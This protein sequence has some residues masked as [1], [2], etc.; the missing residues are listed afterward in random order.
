MEKAIQEELKALWRQQ[1]L[2]PGYIAEIEANLRDRIEAYLDEGYSEEKAFSKAIEKA[3]GNPEHIADQYFTAKAGSKRPPWKSNGLYSILPMNFKLVWRGLNKRRGY[4]IINLSGL[5]VGISIS[6]LLWLYVSDQFSYDQHLSESHRVYRINYDLTFDSQQSI[7]SNVAQPVGPALKKEFPEIEEVV[8][9]YKRGADHSAVFSHGEIAFKSDKV[10]YAEEAFLKVFKI[11]ML[12]GDAE[13]ALKE[14]NSIVISEKLAKQLFSTSDVMGETVQLGNDPSSIRKITGIIKD[15]LKTHLP[16]EALLSASI[17][18]RTDEHRW[19]GAHVYTY[20]LLDQH[21]DIEGLKK[22]IP[23]FCER[24]IDDFFERKGAKADLLFQP[25]EEIYLD[26]E[27]IWEL[28]P[29]GNRTNLWVMVAMMFFLIVIAAINYVNLSTAR[30]TE[31]AREVGIR[32]T[33]GSLKRV[34]IGQFMTESMVIT[35]LSG[36][37]SIFLSVAL[38]PFF[39]TLSGLETTILTILTP[40]HLIGILLLSLIIGL[41]AG[42]YPAFYLVSFQPISMLTGRSAK[43]RS[44]DRFRTGLVLVQYSLSS[45]LIIG[46]LF[47]GKQTRFIMNKELG[48]N[49][50]QLVSLKVPDELAMSNSV[51]AFMQEVSS[52]SSIL[53]ATSSYNTLSEDAN[54][55]D[56]IFETPDGQI[57]NTSM[58]RIDIDFNFLQTIQADIIKGR[59]FEETRGDSERRSIVLNEAAVKQYGWE[60]IAT[61]LKLR[62]KN[63]DEEGN[64]LYQSVIGVVSDFSIGPSYQKVAPL[65]IKL[66]EWGARNIYIRVQEESTLNA[67]AHIEESWKETFPGY[68]FDF[69]F[70]DQELNNIYERESMFLKLLK[71][72]TFLI[73]FITSLGIIG[74]ISFTI[75]MKQKE[76]AIR[77]INGAS[78]PAIVRLL[79]Q[80]FVRLLFFAN[81]IAAPIAFYFTRK[82]LFNYDQHVSITAWPFLWSVVI[83]LSFTCMALIYHSLQAAGTNPARAL[84]NE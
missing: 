73:I 5:A 65:M 79:S 18:T 69:A 26:E 50:S 15:H 82:W 8:R 64:P 33:L 39:D 4:T 47:V 12:A 9:F 49:K 42:I 14:P 48:Y 13:D 1:G 71:A 19:L 27:H 45:L 59:D 32:K 17:P 58:N 56:P 20:M 51:S 7:Y 75:E 6:F 62:S 81:L 36:V 29:H 43:G 22:K 78:M 16:V 80:K 67:I 55:N 84:R 38:L 31:R 30:A 25:L 40:L 63:T 54:A 3:I 57:V 21:N 72:M 53:S 44:G 37:L 76:I 70:L 28:Y 74:L 46:M 35:M 10:F 77:K 11:G 24:Y 68:A 83:C 23:A 61:H 34:L 2:E 41:I 66:N 60:N 52:K